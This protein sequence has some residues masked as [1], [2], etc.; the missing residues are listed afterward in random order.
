MKRSLVWL[1][2]VGVSAVLLSCEALAIGQSCP[3]PGSDPSTTPTIPTPVTAECGSVSADLKA[4]LIE[5]GYSETAA[6]GIMGNIWAES[7]YV[8]KKVEGKSQLV[9]DDFVAFSNGK[10]S[11]QLVSSKGSNLGF[12][13]AQWTTNGRVKNLQTYANSIGKGVTTF[14]AQAGYL[15]QEL[16]SSSYS[17]ANPSSLNGKSIEEV[18]YLI[19]RRFEIPLSSFCVG[20][21]CGSGKTNQS[22]PPRDYASFASS[23]SSYALATSAFNSR[24]GAAKSALTLDI[25]KCHTAGSDAPSGGGQTGGTDVVSTGGGAQPTTAAASG[26]LGK[27]NV[28]GMLSQNDGSVKNLSWT[29]SSKTIG[30]SG[31]SL[32]AVVNAERALGKSGAS[33]SALAGWAKTAISSPSWGAIDKMAKHEG[34]SIKSGSAC[35]DYLW[36]NKGTSEATKIQQIRSVLA[37]GGVVIAGGDRAGTD[38]SFCTSTKISDGSCVF[39]PGGHFVTIIGITADDK[40]VIANPARSNGRNWIFPAS[41]VLK[42]SNKAKMVKF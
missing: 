42:Y 7:K 6:A 4:Y 33:A 9:A 20:S 21:K 18:T 8:L 28:N 41:N 38:S 31:C 17:F 15:L 10:R 1:G 36:C 35:A 3:I 32:I 16:T 5:N 23:P 22:E 34:L 30:A 37:S 19:Y 14:E 12:G 26:A 25:S 29:T 40:L 2:A 24:L 27:Q 13:L 39:T 11:S